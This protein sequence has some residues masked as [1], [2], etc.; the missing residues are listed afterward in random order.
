M[1]QYRTNPFSAARSDESAM[2]PFAKLLTINY[3]YESGVH[4]I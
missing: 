4:W 3:N 2:W 1:G